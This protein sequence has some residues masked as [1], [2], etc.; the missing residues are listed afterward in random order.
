VVTD[1]GHPAASAEA[2]GDLTRIELFA[3]T[4]QAISVEVVSQPK[5]RVVAGVRKTVEYDAPVLD[6]T[7]PGHGHTRLA[8]AGDHVD[9]AV[10]V[11]PAGIGAAGSLGRAEHLPVLSGLPLDSLL[12]GLPA[13]GAAPGASA[14]GPAK[15]LIGNLPGVPSLGGVVDDVAGGLLSGDRTEHTTLPAGTGGGVVVLRLSLGELAQVT[16]ATGV[17]AKAASLRVKVLTRSTWAGHT[18]DDATLADDTALVDLGLCVLEAAAGAP[19][20]A[21]GHNG[22]GYG[23][24]YGSGT[25]DT[26][27][28]GGTG[29]IT[30]TTPTP[31]PV[32][33]T[34]SLPVTGNH[35]AYALG[36]G[37]LLVLVGRFLMVMTRKRSLV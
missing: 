9:V 34:G 16:T 5:L 31:T 33:H 3:G 20:A 15:N 30:G 18:A 13:G 28:P 14:P 17:H 27:H 11:D 4:P 23:S 19:K 10:P 7:L 1:A 12:G 35:V 24:G 36:G 2:D 32:A 26:G 25:G 6:V 22:G 21:H 29:G 37:V 8:A